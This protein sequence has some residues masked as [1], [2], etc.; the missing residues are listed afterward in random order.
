MALPPSMSSFLCSNE[1]SP[2]PS[3]FSLSESTRRLEL[4][5]RANIP[6]DG[7]FPASMTHPPL[8]AAVLCHACCMGTA[9]AYQ[10]HDLSGCLTDALYQFLLIHYLLSCK[11]RASRKICNVYSP[12]SLQGQILRCALQ[13]NF[14][15]EI[16]PSCATHMA[17]H[18]RNAELYTWLEGLSWKRLA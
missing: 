11:S 18:Q 15:I 10:P 12:M 14:V 13:C 2:F 9:S 5:Q 3:V 4:E 6:S 8:L 7:Q 16:Y 1:H 17:L